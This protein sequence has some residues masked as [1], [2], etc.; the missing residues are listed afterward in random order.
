MAIHEINAGSLVI[1]DLCDV[2]G[3]EI[4]TETGLPLM[5]GAIVSSSAYCP[6]C[7]EKYK[8]AI[9]YGEVEMLDPTKTFGNN[10]RDYRFQMHGTPDCITRIY[11]AEDYHD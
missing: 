11:T 10:V 5:G 6:K 8:V 4:D 9:R 3:D 1:C 7:V 2:D